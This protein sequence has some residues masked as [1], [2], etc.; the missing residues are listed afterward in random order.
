[1]KKLSLSLFFL[2]VSF[3]TIASDGYKLWLQYYPFE[4]QAVSDYYRDYLE[5]INI[6]GSSPTI[7]IIQKEL[8]IAASGFLNSKVKP[9]FKHIGDSNICWI[10]KTDDLP[11][12]LKSAFGQKV[13]EIGKEGYWLK[14]HLGRVIITANSD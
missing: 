14:Y 10:G 3:I 2:L 8:E 1:M 12:D 13:N 7:D 9:T 11:K 4:N 5:N 6:V